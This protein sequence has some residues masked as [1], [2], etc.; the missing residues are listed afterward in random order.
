MSGYGDGLFNGG[1]E[2]GMEGGN[3]DRHHGGNQYV[4]E[5]AAQG[6]AQGAGGA[7]GQGA[8]QGAAQG[9]APGFEDAGGYCCFADYRKYFVVYHGL[10]QVIETGSNT[11]L[12]GI[13]C[14]RRGEPVTLYNISDCRHNYMGQI[15][16]PI[17]VSMASRILIDGDDRYHGYPSRA[18]AAL[19]QMD[20]VL[21]WSFPDFAAGGMERPTGWLVIEYALADAL[22]AWVAQRAP[23]VAVEWRLPELLDLSDE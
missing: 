18:S 15:R 22:A 10:L 2:Y 16:G 19:W 8:A 6:A 11:R 20:V 4:V 3:A 12:S 23:A 5:G 1:N 14:T 9:F 13:T 17:E 7:A 21:R